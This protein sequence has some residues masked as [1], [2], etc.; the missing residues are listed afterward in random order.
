MS[1]PSTDVYEEMIKE[2]R[3]FHRKN[4]A[5]LEK[6]DDFEK[7][8]RPEEAIRWYSSNSFVY[9]LVN[10]TLRIQNLTILF[11]FRFFIPDLCEQLKKLYQEQYLNEQVKNNKY[12]FLFIQ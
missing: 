5:Q 12:Q 10:K 8:Y 11:K 7:H 9:R 6:I 4:P 3:F 2:A 1:A